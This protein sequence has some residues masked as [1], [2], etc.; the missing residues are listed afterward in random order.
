LMVVQEQLVELDVDVVL[1]VGA[2]SFDSTVPVA[3]AGGSVEPGDVHL[4]VERVFEQCLNEVLVL[5]CLAFRCGLVCCLQ[6]SGCCC[7]CQAVRQLRWGNGP[8]SVPELRMSSTKT[9]RPV[10]RSE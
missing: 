10:L 3:F 5:H 8:S 7:R 4:R 9:W 6:S 1:A 2:E